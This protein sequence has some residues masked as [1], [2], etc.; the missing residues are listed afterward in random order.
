MYVANTYSHPSFCS[1]LI[2][3]CISNICFTREDRWNTHGGGAREEKWKKYL[4]RGTRVVSR[5]E[6]RWCN[7]LKRARTA[8]ERESEGE[9]KRNE[10]EHSFYM[11][12]SCYFETQTCICAAIAVCARAPLRSHV[13]NE[14]QC[15]ADTYRKVNG[16]T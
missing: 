6:Q 5:N 4:A 12:S 16:A 9:R 1:R 14:K 15:V 2:F 10:R 11:A 7:S 3:H 8:R 13:K